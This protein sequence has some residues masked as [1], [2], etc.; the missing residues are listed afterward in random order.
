MHPALEFVTLLDPSPEAT[1]CVETR[2]DVPSG[3]PKPDPDPLYARY[4]DLTLANVEQ[5]IPELATANA[6]GAAVYVMVNEC[7]GP[8]RKANVTRIRGVHADFDG[9]SAETLAAVR[10]RLQPTIEVQSSTPDRVHFYWLLKDGE[11]MPAYLAEMIN[12]GL[13]G[14]G[15]DKGASDFSRQLRL[16]GFRHMKYR[17]GRLEA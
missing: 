17:D 16:P 7:D 10:A 1:F 15:A 2:T 3:S 8:R 9:V 6:A 11:E 13:V 14:L 4:C 5:L 12:R